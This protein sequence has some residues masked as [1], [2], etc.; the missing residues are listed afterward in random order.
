MTEQASGMGI[1]SAAL[2]AE[3]TQITHPNDN[4]GEVTNTDRGKPAHQSSR[5]VLGQKAPGFE[6]N[7][8]QGK[9]VKLSD[10]AGKTIVLEWFN[11][12][13]PFVKL[14]HERELSLKHKAKQYRGKNV[15]WLAINSAGPGK[16]GHGVEANA[17][18]K[19]RFG[20]DYPILLD[21]TGQVGRMYEAK[22]TP[23][24]FI[25]DTKGV[26]VYDG[27]ID[28]TMGGD[29]DDADPP[30]AVSFVDKALAN[31][32]AGKAIEPPKTTP[33]GCTVKYAE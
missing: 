1:D 14:A 15:A 8:L 30:P 12:G 2:S 7:D 6:L 26:L 4:A 19:K 5:A 24:M 23:H 11:P 28:N 13:C 17:R 9:P 22:R 25:I 3:Q 21:P 33:W 31:L 29:E 32:Q 16:Q 27:A 10:Y 18:F 20:I